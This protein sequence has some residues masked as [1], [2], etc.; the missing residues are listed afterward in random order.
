VQKVAR[1]KCP[2]TTCHSVPWRARRLPWDVTTQRRRRRCELCQEASAKSVGRP[3][4]RDAACRAP[5]V[6]RCCG[7]YSQIKLTCWHRAVTHVRLVSSGL[8][9]DKVTDCATMDSHVVDMR[10]ARA[11]GMSMQEIP[12]CVLSRFA[13]PLSSSAPS[14]KSNE[15]RTRGGSPSITDTWN[16]ASCR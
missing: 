9:C 2:R 8:L 4:A 16:C 7:A 12:R 15:L 5:P 1:C 6:R 10:W 11:S 3:L 14:S 13:P